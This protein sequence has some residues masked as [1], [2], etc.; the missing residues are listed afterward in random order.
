MKG[1]MNRVVIVYVDSYDNSVPVGRFRLAAS[2]NI[3]TFQ[4]LSQLLLKINNELEAAQ[5]PQ[6]FDELRKFHDPKALPV[7]PP[8]TA[9]IPTGDAA[10]FTIRILFRQNASW[11]GTITWLEGKQEQSF[12]SVLELIF[13]MDNALEFANAPQ[14]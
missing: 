5:F 3:Q 6:A 1:E 14:E 12:R 4:S 13:L 8:E 9:E 11:Q 2:Q 7:S 10:T